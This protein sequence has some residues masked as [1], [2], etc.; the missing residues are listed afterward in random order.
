MNVASVVSSFIISPA[1]RRLLRSFGL[2]KNAFDSTP[3]WCS[4]RKYSVLLVTQRFHI[5]YACFEGRGTSYSV[6][7]LLI[8]GELRLFYSS[9]D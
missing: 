5:N 8:S 3:E 6:S 9:T 2:F 1:Q 7:E 4:S